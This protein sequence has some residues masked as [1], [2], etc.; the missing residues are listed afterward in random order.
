MN[1]AVKLLLTIVVYVA[2]V[3]ALAV[4]SLMTPPPEPIE[5]RDD[6]N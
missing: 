1:P 6:D 5:V 2:L 4:V 3:V